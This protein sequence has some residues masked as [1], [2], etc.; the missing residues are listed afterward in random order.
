MDCSSCGFDRVRSRQAKIIKG[1]KK[2]GYY[3]KIRHSPQSLARRLASPLFLPAASSCHEALTAAYLD[4]AGV[5]CA[6][7][8][9]LMRDSAEVLHASPSSASFP[10]LTH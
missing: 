3:P 9:A 6:E 4:K 8:D 1:A 5:A 2:A 10:H 7:A